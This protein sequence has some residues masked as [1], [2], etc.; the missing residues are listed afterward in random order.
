M[1]KE[2][3]FSQN[4][5]TY[6]KDWQNVSTPEYPQIVSR[7]EE[8]IENENDFTESPKKQK[9]KRDTPR[10]LLIIIQLIVCLLIC[11]CAYVLKNIGGDLYNT[12]HSWY[13]A[14]LNNE[15]IAEG[16]LN[17]IDLSEI[18]NT[19]NSATNDEV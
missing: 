13:E 1:E 14:E 11:L 10:Q 12:L 17:N 4:E 3:S 19:N 7:E 15:V 8:Q 9:K 18:L 6:D 2:K 5:I 16:M